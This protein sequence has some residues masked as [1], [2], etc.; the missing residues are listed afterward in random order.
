[1]KGSLN[2][3]MHSH[4]EKRFACS[5]CGKGFIWK[6]SLRDHMTIHMANK[7]YKCG[8]CDK[9]FRTLSMLRRHVSD[10]HDDA[11]EFVCNVCNKQFRYVSALTDHM[12]IHSGDQKDT[13]TYW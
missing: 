12:H 3:Y 6:Y 8:S 11:G 7:L 13:R 4:G 2:S 1:M 10:R 5:I 9:E